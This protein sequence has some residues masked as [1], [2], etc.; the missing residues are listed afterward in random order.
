MLVA[1]DV[2]SEG[3]NLHRANVVINYDIPWNPTR[4]MQRV[5]RI[6]RVDTAF[7]IIYTYNFFPS[8]HGNDQI[9]L[10]EA[11]EAKIHAFI[12]LL[13]ADARLLTDGETVESHELFNRLM[14]RKTI[15]GEDEADDT[16]LKY[17]QIIRDIRDKNPDLF[18]KIKRL[19][20][21]ARTARTIAITARSL[22]TYFRKGKIQKFFS[23]A[24]DGC[25]EL[26]FMAAAQMLEAET[27][28]ARA[29][30]GND[31]FEL[32]E[33]NKHA[34][35]LATMPDDAEPSARGG[36]DS[37]TQIIRILKAIRD[38][39]Q[40]TDEQESY[41]AKL[42]KRLEEGGLPR[43]TT[44]KALLELNKAVKSGGNAVNPLKILALVQKYVPR[45]LM[46]GHLIDSSGNTNSP[47][48]VILSEYFSKGE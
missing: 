34:F 30:W 38:F 22:L 19:P 11:A 42:L 4:L 16:E 24:G 27:S 15:T 13:G 25:A 23:A 21:K 8:T 1:T 20:K 7:P 29:S 48:E 2:L 14:S 36:R 40:F 45:R 26:D 43:Q 5:G 39:R 31:F 35:E 12:S 18:S 3:V 32:L 6:N 41:L 46:E 9:K 33:R 10:R 47:S 44:K 17:L 28:T 37:A